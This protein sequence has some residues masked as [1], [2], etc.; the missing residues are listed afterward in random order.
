MAAPQTGQASSATA[1]PGSGDRP[2]MSARHRVE[3]DVVQGALR[4]DGGDERAVRLAPPVGRR[5][6][7]D[8]PQ[9]GRG[10]GVPRDVAVPEDQDVGVREAGRAPRFAT[11]LVTGLVYDR[12]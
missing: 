3:R 10:R 11:V 12:D 6:G 1:W 9:A 2:V 4:G 7:V 5:A 8:Q